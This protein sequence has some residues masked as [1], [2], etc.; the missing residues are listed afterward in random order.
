MALDVTD[1]I[2]LHQVPIVLNSSQCCINILSSR[3]DQRVHTAST[4][5]ERDLTLRKK[6]V[7]IWRSLK[8]DLG[9]FRAIWQVS[10]GG[11]ESIVCDA[12]R[13]FIDMTVWTVLVPWLLAVS[14]NGSRLACFAI[15]RGREV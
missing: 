1:S 11:E 2:Q 3:H 12:E 15:V 14:C 13:Q 10:K 5:K 8:F 6:S 7:A 9:W 4:A